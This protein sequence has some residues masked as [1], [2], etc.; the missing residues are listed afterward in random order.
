MAQSLS[1]VELTPAHASGRYHTLAL[2]VRAHRL[3]RWVQ[4]GYVT[5]SG[6]VRPDLGFLKRLL[7]GN[8]SFSSE[9]AGKLNGS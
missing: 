5:Q 6:P 3:P 4:G 9:V 8:L 2:P 1:S 7:R